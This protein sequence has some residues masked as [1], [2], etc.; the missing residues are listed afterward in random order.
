MFGESFWVAVAFVLFIGVLIYFKVPALIAG[1]LDGRSRKIRDQL[2]EAQRLREEA[3]AL[4]AEYQ[5]K[6]QSALKD[7]GDIVALAEAESE[8]QQ[9]AATVELKAALARRQAL[10]EQRI[11]QAETAAVQEIR[12]AA[13]ELAVEAARRVII[14]Q[15]KGPAANA[16]IDR[17]IDDLS[18]KLH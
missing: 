17:A 12:N 8:R 7:A 15:M 5:K 14:E 9:A 4:F 11:Q 3:Q 10:A 6:Q 18:K 13:A 1:L 16:A 2:A